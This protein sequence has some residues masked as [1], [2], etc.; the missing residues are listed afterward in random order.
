EP[1]AEEPEAEEP[2]AQETESDESDAEEDD[3]EIK[4]DLAR[5]YLSLGDKEAS[6]SMLEDVLKSGDAAQKAEAQKMMDEL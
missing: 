5:A 3:P 4:L 6:R 1:E 2:E